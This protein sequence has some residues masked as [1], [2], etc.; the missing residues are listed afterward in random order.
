LAYLYIDDQDIE[1]SVQT[2][3]EPINNKT[4]TLRLISLEQKDILN[5][6]PLN[7]LQDNMVQSGFGFTYEQYRPIWSPDGRNIVIRIWEE[8]ERRGYP[9]I[10]KAFLLKLGHSSKALVNLGD[11]KEIK[12]SPDSNWLAMKNNN[13]IHIFEMSL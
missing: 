3:M 12:W 6:I 9:L 5:D 11:A 10:S 2:G 7:V 8:N 4:L 13:V 1:Q